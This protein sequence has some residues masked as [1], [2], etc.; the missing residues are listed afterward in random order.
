[1]LDYISEK[2]R[3]LLGIQI[4]AFYTN[5]KHRNVDWSYMTALGLGQQPENTQGKERRGGRA[6]TVILEMYWMEGS[7]WVWSLCLILSDG[8]VESP[9]RVATSSSTQE[10]QDEKQQ[11]M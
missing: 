5:L 7:V 3:A 11:H 10:Q 1:M 9:H 8:D 6:T 2:Y 4:E